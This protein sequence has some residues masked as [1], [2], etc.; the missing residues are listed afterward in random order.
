M[1]DAPCCA[2]G[3]RPDAEAINAALRAGDGLGTVAKRHGLVKGT[4]GRHRARCLGIVIGATPAADAS[5]G[6]PSQE[7][8]TARL[9][10]ERRLE[11]AEETGERP[12]SPFAVPNPGDDP[13]TAPRKVVA[14]AL[15]QEATDLRATGMSY[16]LIGKKLGV[17]ADTAMDAVER[18]LLR[19]RRG[20]D[21]KAD[22]ARRLD[23][24]RVDQLLA[25]LWERATDP[26]MATVDVP[27]DTETG[28][29]AYEGQDKAV[30]R[31]VKL[32]ER[33]AKLLGLDAS[34][35]PAVQVQIL[36]NPNVRP[37]VEAAFKFVFDVLVDFPEAR[38]AVEEQLVRAMAGGTIPV[39]EL[40][41]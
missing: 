38:A 24:M 41:E 39:P 11:N 16:L 32:L 10:T 15:E 4:V 28:I 7:P 37:H 13:L 26:A 12:V 27:A 23:L 33:R 17:A 21:E 29:K 31:V 22:A 2:V 30:D 25:G 1:P 40:P 34:T 6:D 20:A 19:T 18:V 36:Q 35:G 5:D 3:A 9:K 14:A 8:A